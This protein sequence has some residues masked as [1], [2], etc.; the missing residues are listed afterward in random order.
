MY[1]G[2][3]KAFIPGGTFRGILAA[4]A[5]KPWPYLKQELL[6]SLF[7]ARDLFHAPDLLRFAYRTYSCL[8]LTP[9]NKIFL[10]R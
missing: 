8:K 2:S 10:Q 1:K 5:C 3:M 6:L 9:S 7:K 4:E